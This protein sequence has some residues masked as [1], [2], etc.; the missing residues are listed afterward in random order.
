MRGQKRCR[1]SQ[2]N[3]FHSKTVHTESMCCLFPTNFMSS[4]YRQ[5]K[6]LSRFPNKHSEFGTVS[7]ACSNRTFSNC[8]SHTKPFSGFGNQIVPLK[9]TNRAQLCGFWKHVSFITLREVHACG[10]MIDVGQLKVLGLSLKF[11]SKV[12]GFVGLLLM[13]QV[14]QNASLFCGT[15]EPSRVRWNV[16]S[17][18]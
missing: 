14:C 8:L 12:G 9:S 11:G 6:F 7:H 15:L 3:L 17:L 13:Q 18:V 5:K 16:S 10:D 2:V 4:T 1:F